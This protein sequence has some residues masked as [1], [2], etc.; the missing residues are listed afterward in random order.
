VERLESW[1]EIAAY[2]RRGVRTVRRWEKEEG[3]PVHRHLHQKL[4]TVY[5]YKP[6]IDTWWASRRSRLETQLAESE[7]DDGRGRSWGRRAIVAIGVAVL[8]LAVAASFAW[9][10]NA[11]PA[12]APAARVMLAVLPF[13]NLGDATA[14]TY[15]SDGLTEDLITELGRIHP[16]RLGVIA[17][18]SVMQYKGRRKTVRQIGEELGVRY[19]LEGS[20][21]REGETLRIT[22]QLIGAADQTHLWAQ[23]YDRP[24]RDLLQVQGEIAGAIARAIAMELPVGRPARTQAGQD[25]HDAVLRGRYLL[26]LRTEGAIRGAIEQFERA[27]QSSPRYAMAHVGLAEAYSLLP[28]YADVP[29]AEGMTRA[30]QETQE[31]LRLDESTAEAHAILG[32]ILTEY[33]WDWAGAEQEF[34]RAIHDN[35]NYAYAHKLYA[36]YLSYM[37]RFDEAI[38]EARI[39]LELDP[40]SPVAN[41]ML[42]TMYYTAR[43]YDLALEQLRRTTERY[44]NHPLAYMVL[45]LT[46]G[47]KRLHSEAITALETALRLSG[48]N[49]EYLAQLAGAYARAG[50]EEQARTMLGELERRSRAQYVSPFLYALVQTGLGEHRHALDRLEESFRARLWLMCVLNTEPIFDPLRSDPR[51]QK[52]LRRM[53]FPH[54]ASS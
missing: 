31:A 4:G 46:Y 6:E 50:Q 16:D 28:T 25:V 15:L 18:T 37:G 13:E 38:A 51:F 1:K 40:V 45:G 44:P 2:L 41:A 7:R 43:R 22:A 5:A 9:R 39:A 35:A 26:E 3:L 11:V 29:S 19:V 23:R 34:R 8:G 14:H 30:R 52:L 42:G 32:M 21:Q 33:D 49:S 53:Q 17:R 24:P 27:V 48:N 12:T 10:R 47:Q 54:S 20:V 36:E